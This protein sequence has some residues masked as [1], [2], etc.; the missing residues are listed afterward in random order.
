MESDILGPLRK[1][2]ELNK[3]DK[4]EDK[5][6]GGK[7]TRLWNADLTLNLHKLQFYTTIA[8]RAPRYVAPQEM[9]LGCTEHE[10]QDRRTHE[11]SENTDVSRTRT[12]DWTHVPNLRH[13]RDDD[14]KRAEER[15]RRRYAQ[16]QT[17]CIFPILDVVAPV[18]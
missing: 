6:R 16:R 8:G 2:K 4:K 18:L 10:I 1:S 9:Q 13:G 7:P 11:A 14:P 17:P 15:K 5:K 3:K 12:R